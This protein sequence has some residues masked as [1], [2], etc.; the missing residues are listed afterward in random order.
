MLWHAVTAPSSPQKATIHT[1]IYTHTD[2]DQKLYSFYVG[3]E[4]LAA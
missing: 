1:Q 2:F 3:E 4:L